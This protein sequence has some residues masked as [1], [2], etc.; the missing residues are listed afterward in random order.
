MNQVLSDNVLITGLDK[1]QHFYPIDKIKAHIDGVLHLAISIF[2]VNEK[3]ELL[4]QRRALDKYHSGGL[5]ANSC[6]SHPSFGENEKTCAYRRLE[7][8]LGIKTNL[9]IVNNIDYKC[10]VGNLIE[11]E[12][13]T[14]FQGFLDSSQ[15]INFNEREVMEIRWISIANLK[16]EAEK[17]P[18]KFA[19]WLHVYL[20]VGLE[21]ILHL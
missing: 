9:T 6:C 14:W 13:V 15:P 8:E 11:N 17:N 18:Q 2:L 16:K 5:W 10:N 1:Q 7:E 19:N 4:L 3:K 12:R 20:S 21:N